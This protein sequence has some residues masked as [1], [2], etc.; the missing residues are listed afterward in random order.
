MRC[1]IASTSFHINSNA[2]PAPKPPPGL[3]RPKEQKRPHGRK[4]PQG[5]R[6]LHAPSRPHAPNAPRVLNKLHVP[7]KPHARKT[8]RGGGNSSNA[9]VHTAAWRKT[10]MTV[11]RN[12]PVLRRAIGPLPE[13]Q[14][15]ST[16]Q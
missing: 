2:W 13:R 8:S 14:P 11:A 3:R 6:L 1:T 10:A 5:L 7:S 15:R 9:S 4:K 16:T 12:S